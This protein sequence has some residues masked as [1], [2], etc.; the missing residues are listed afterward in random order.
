MKMHDYFEY[1]CILLYEKVCVRGRE[2]L[3]HAFCQDKTFTHT[4]I[5]LWGICFPAVATVDL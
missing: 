2:G 3:G 1:S 4:C 5:E